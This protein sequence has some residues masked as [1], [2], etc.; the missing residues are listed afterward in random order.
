MNPAKR[1]FQDRSPSWWPWPDK[2]VPSNGKL[3]DYRRRLW[4][5]GVVYV[6]HFHNTDFTLSDRGWKFPAPI[7]I[8]P[9]FHLFPSGD[10]SISHFHPGA[11]PLSNDHPLY[12]LSNDHDVHSKPIHFIQGKKRK[13]YRLRVTTQTTPAIRE[14]MFLYS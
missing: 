12:P 10:I 9:Y 6:F 7:S 8:R 14:C 13:G 1:L 11:Y 3:K 5:R 2:T 4:R